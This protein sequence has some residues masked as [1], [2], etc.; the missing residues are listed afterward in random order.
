MCY[1]R[2]IAFAGRARKTGVKTWLKQK[3]RFARIVVR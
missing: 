3:E 1:L 2:T